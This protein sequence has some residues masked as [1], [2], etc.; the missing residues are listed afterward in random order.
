MLRLEGVSKSFGPG[1]PALA[2]VDLEFP[3]GRITAVVG[4]TGSGKSTL[5]RLLTGLA[6][7]TS[8]RVVMGEASPA[9][10]VSQLIDGPRPDFSIMFQEP[11]LLPWLTVEDNVRLGLGHLRPDTQ[12]ALARDALAQVGLLACAAALPKTLSGGMA[13]RAAFARAI[14]THPRVL[15]LDEPF[16][17]L[18]ALTRARLQ[19]F[20][21][22]WW[23]QH[24]ATLVLV[25]HDVEEAVFFAHQVVVLEGPPGRVKRRFAVDLPDNR[26]RDD[27]ALLGWK[28]RIRAEL[29]TGR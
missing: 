23:H 21:A 11:R 20:V 28:A 5:L 18:D 26:Q 17:A 29:E 4:T 16:S 25:T 19:D 14:V 3:E 8:G 9:P 13:Q 10:D 1:A 2:S 15:F 24:R 6:A 27:P 7:P 12:K 22:S